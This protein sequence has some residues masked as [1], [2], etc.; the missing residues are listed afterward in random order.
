MVLAV[1][2]YVWAEG[3]GGLYGKAPVLLTDSGP[4]LLSDKPLRDRRT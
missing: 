1:T 4:E 2:A 3:I